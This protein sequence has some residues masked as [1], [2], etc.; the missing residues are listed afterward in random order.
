MLLGLLA[1]SLAALSRD[2]AAPNALVE[3]GAA[4]EGASACG[5]CSGHGACSPSG[6]CLCGIGWT[7]DQCSIDTC[8]QH[9]AGRGVCLLGRCSC[10]EGYA[11]DDCS[12]DAG[13]SYDHPGIYARCS[14]HGMLRNGECV[15][16][17]FWQGA[18]C[19]LDTCPSHCSG[20][21]TCSKGVCKCDDSW[22]GAA[23]ELRSCPG[24]PPCS[25]H[26]A[27]D[28]QSGT[29]A[30]AYG[31]LAA[32]CSISSCPGGCNDHGYCLGR[33]CTCVEGWTGEA[34]D[35]AVGGGPVGGG[36]PEGRVGVPAACKNH[37]SGRGRC[38]ADECHC[39]AG[40][41][42]PPNGPND[43]SVIKCVNDCS[44]HGACD[45]ARGLCGCDHGWNGHACSVP[46]CPN[47]CSRR[48]YCLGGTCACPACFAGAD[49]ATR[50]HDTPEC[51]AARP[52]GGPPPPPAEPWVASPPPPVPDPAASRQVLPVTP[53]M[54]RPV[55]DAELP[56]AALGLFADARGATEAEGPS[57]TANA[58]EYRGEA[59]G[60]AHGEA[61]PGVNATAPMASPPPNASDNAS[62]VAAQPSQG[63]NASVD[64]A[65]APGVTEP[66][67]APQPRAVPSH[68]RI[69]LAL[70]HSL[71]AGV[72]A[73]ASFVVFLVSA[74][75][76]HKRFGSPL[77]R[78]ML[79]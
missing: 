60:E 42:G 27:C 51:G 17:E 48:G 75:V 79:A 35:V 45:T 52:P 26:G 59:H 11:G 23:C 38:V 65:A 50:V 74:V 5:G 24:T 72:V 54:L 43:C 31:W 19:D 44:G 77:K 6:T 22:E 28:H 25:S 21:G 55:G 76:A 39:R 4:P 9:C 61:A 1:P 53:Q 36:M 70:A 64:D 16:Y 7:G 37:C 14:G 67:P 18:A 3:G 78:P 20:H 13:V 49:C 47:E 66:P 62:G 33:V 73:I 12:L 32:D 68:R 46:S 15:C 63:I 69:D 40:Y 8:P 2:A 57:P 10:F 56:A 58:S 34:C 71:L 41:T 29:C 30:C